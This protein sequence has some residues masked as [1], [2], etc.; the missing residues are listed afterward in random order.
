MNV[1]LDD[2]R[3][4]R[5]AIIIGD[6]V[7]LAEG[8]RERFSYLALRAMVSSS[9]AQAHSRHLVVPRRSSLSVRDAI[10]VA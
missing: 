10:V 8:R 1:S 7:A 4:R 9:P 6:I 5:A 2:G 3:R